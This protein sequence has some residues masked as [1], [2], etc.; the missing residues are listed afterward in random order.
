M[1]SPSVVRPRLTLGLTNARNTPE[2]VRYVHSFVRAAAARSLH[3]GLY[4]P[5][6]R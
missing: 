4:A 1:R 6:Y 5:G 3:V 2:Y